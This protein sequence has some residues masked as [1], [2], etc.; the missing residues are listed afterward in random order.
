MSNEIDVDEFADL[1]VG[2][3]DVEDDLGKELGDVA[4]FGDKLRGVLILSWLMFDCTHSN[5]A[6]H[7]VQLVSVAV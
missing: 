3:G 5:Q 7:G 4:T 1:E 6:F 2:R